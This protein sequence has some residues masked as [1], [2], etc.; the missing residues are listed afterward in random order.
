MIN[1]KLD[2]PMVVGLGVAQTGRLSRIRLL[3]AR[4]TPG[5]Q[6]NDGAV[7]QDPIQ[8]SNR[9]SHEMEA[10]TSGARYPRLWAWA[11]RGQLRELGHYAVGRRWGSSDPRAANLVPKYYGV[12]TFDEIFTPAAD[13]HHPRGRM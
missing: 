10:R 4:R 5:V 9:G 12:N 7:A 3:L 11:R 13:R 1:L 2:P 6:T 8:V